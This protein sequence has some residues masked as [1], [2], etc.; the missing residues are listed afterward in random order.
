MPTVPFILEAV[1]SIQERGI[2]DNARLLEEPRP[3]W[4]GEAGEFEAMLAESKKRAAQI[5][6]QNK[7]EAVKHEFPKAAAEPISDLEWQ[8]R[9]EEQLRQFREKNPEAVK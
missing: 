5:S 4:K 2:T 6:D 9:R 8:R 1:A 3:D 7:A